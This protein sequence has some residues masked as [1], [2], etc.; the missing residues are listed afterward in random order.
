MVSINPDAVLWSAP[1]IERADRPLLVL[2]HGYGSHE[3]DLFGLSQYLPLSPVIASVQAPFPEGN[4]Y[5]WFPIDSQNP[6]RLETATASA[7]AVLDWID[8]LSFTSVGVLGF[9]QGGAIALQAMRLAPARFSY[10]AN[11]SGFALPG[12]LDGD[13][14]LANSRPPVFW[15]RGTLDQVIQPAYIDHTSSWLP[16]HSTLTERIYEG[17]AHGISMPELTDI[18][19]FIEGQLP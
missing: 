17:V 18:S 16:T 10:T 9:S 5:S 19:A 13:A 12:V 11:L 2:L 14:V 6:A 1:E 4:G 8:T 15:G 3:G 7:R